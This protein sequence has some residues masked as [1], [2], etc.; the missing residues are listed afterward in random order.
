MEAQKLKGALE[1]KK[2]SAICL[3]ITILLL[4]VMQV[5][6]AEV[7]TVSPRY[8]NAYDSSTTLSIDSGR[9]YITVLC[10]AKATAINITAVTY[11]EHCMGT[12]WYRIYIGTTNN[13]W[14]YTTTGSS[15]DLAYDYGLNM[16]GKYRAVTVFTII[17]TSQSETITRTCEATF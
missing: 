14:V 12:T 5:S 17:G 4:S 10:T 8:V 11:I 9:A 2:L 15:V 7:H 13:E 3:V 6:A 16:P 1:M